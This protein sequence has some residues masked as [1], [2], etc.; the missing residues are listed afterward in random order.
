MAHKQRLFKGVA[1]SVRGDFPRRFARMWK[2]KKTKRGMVSGMDV[3]LE[4]SCNLSL[5]AL[6]GIFAY[7][8]QCKMIITEWM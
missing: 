7:R 8:S 5:C 3:G 1:H 4:E 6:V 2:L